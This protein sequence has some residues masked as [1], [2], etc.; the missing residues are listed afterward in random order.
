MT[1]QLPISGD[2]ARA[3]F[4]TKSDHTD[5]EISSIAS[6]LNDAS[7][8]R[9]DHL[10]AEGNNLDEQLD[11]RLLALEMSLRSS[12]LSLATR[13]FLEAPLRPI[14]AYSSVSPVLLLFYTI[15]PKIS[16]NS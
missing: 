13:L 5:S 3:T 16:L 15:K 6:T 11:S 10:G 14:G 4:Q 1:I 9:R 7:S 2:R 8:S 12:N